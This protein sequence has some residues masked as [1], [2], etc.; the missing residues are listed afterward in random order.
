METFDLGVGRSFFMRLFLNLISVILVIGCS[1]SKEQE[2]TMNDLPQGFFEEIKNRK[3]YTTLDVETLSALPDEKLNL[4]IIDYVVHKLKTGSDDGAVIGSLSEGV[5]AF[6]LTSIV[7]GEVYNGGFNQYYWNTEGRYSSEAVTAFEFFSAT[8]HAMLM[9]EAN[10]MR[11]QES[12]TI[13]KYEESDTVEAFSESYKVSNLGLLD[14]RFYA[15]TENLYALRI[16]RIREE[17]A[18]FVGD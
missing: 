11:A 10:A 7:E 17:P 6:W 12:A 2:K 15:L 4:V 3:V 1:D 13:K 14:T 16:A 5:R 8:E 18:L 9:R